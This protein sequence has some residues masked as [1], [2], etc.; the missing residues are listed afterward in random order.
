MFIG[1]GGKNLSYMLYHR[2]IATF[3]LKLCPKLH[4]PVG[5]VLTAS[6]C[7]VHS[8]RHR[9]RFFHVANCGVFFF[10]FTTNVLSCHSFFDCC[11]LYNKNNIR[12]LRSFTN[13]P[14]VKHTV[15]ARIKYV[16][17][18]KEYVCSL[19]NTSQVSI[20][21]LP[22]LNKQWKFQ[23]NSRNYSR[24]SWKQV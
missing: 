14:N 12:R 1:A 11:V 21:P 13:K 18:T 17:Y 9:S 23:T 8:L 4:N 15:N 19:A 22:F 6:H 5:I 16:Q 2:I 3:D 20:W 7:V 10:A 24:Y